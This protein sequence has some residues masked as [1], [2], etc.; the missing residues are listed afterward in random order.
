M[1]EASSTPQQQQAEH[2]PLRLLFVCSRNQRRSVTAERLFRGFSGYETLSAGTDRGARN[3]VT[4]EHIEWADLIFVME[5]HHLQTLQ[6]Q[7]KS[8]LA[9]KRVICLQISDRLGG[10]TLELMDMLKERLSLYLRVP[11]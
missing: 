8:A 3:R 1:F 2:R 11:N 5:S 7:F 9:G 6:S 10:M 4:Q